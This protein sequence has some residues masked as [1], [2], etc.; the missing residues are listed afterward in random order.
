[1]LAV[2]THNLTP[3]AQDRQ[4]DSEAGIFAF[5]VTCLRTLR[6][7]RQRAVE[8]AIGTFVEN[9]GG[10]LTDDIERQIARRF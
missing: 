7:Y 4:A 2:L 3:Y 8:R 5:V 9:R 10:R 6:H 1:M